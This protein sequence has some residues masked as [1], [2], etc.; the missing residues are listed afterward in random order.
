M[1]LTSSW[2][3]MCSTGW[4]SRSLVRKHLETSVAAVPGCTQ[5]QHS[6]SESV[7]YRTLLYRKRTAAAQANGLSTRPWARLG[8]DFVSE[9][10]EM[11]HGGGQNYRRLRRAGAT[12]VRPAGPHSPSVQA[13]LRHLEREGFD[14]APRFVQATATE[15]VLTF[16][17]GEVPQPLEPPADGWPVVSDDRVSSVGA[18][19]RRFH[20]AAST[21]APPPGA[22]WQG[23][24]GTGHVVCHNDPVVGNVVFRGESAVSLIDFDFAGPNDPIR[25]LA[26]AVQ[27]WVPLADPNDLVGSASR[28]SP[29]E[30]LAAMCR[31]YELG[32]DKVTDLMDFVD[33]YLD[34]GRMGVQARVKAGQARFVAYW[35]AGLGGRLERALDWF[36][37]YRAELEKA[38]VS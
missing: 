16:I 10:S 17:D 9:S 14:G 28:W 15:E 27:H 34:R 1:D 2:E 24:S 8:R 29:E 31:E 35:E 37:R 38:V 13:F 6:T 3:G 7:M 11:L 22:H 18:L 5:I 4:A 23:G 36:R 20:I 32:R 19:L 12:V 33:A 25:D 21:F 26:I 30:R